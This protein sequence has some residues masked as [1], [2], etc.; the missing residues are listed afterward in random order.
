MVNSMDKYKKEWRTS[1]KNPDIPKITKIYYGMEFEIA[2]DCYIEG[3]KS[4][5]NNFF[6]N[7]S[8]F[9]P[10]LS[11]EIE[12]LDIQELFSLILAESDS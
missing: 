6:K 11:K 9:F 1:W 8:D 10:L 7:R 2:R 3:E 4:A 12:E 5:I